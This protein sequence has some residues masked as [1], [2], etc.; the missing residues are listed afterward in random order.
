MALLQSEIGMTTTTL[1]AVRE[2]LAEALA[3]H[4]FDAYRYL[5][6]CIALIKALLAERAAAQKRHPLQDFLDAE[7]ECEAAL[8]RFAG[9][10][11]F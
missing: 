1:D 9:R 6:D 4:P 11:D 2:R 3:C 8:S 5:P 10:E 7:D